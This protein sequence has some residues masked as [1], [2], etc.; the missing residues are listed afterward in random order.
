MP[1]Y[2]DIYVISNSRESGNIER[3]LNRFLPEREES[4]DEYEFPQYSDHPEN[5]YQTA[6]ELLERCYSETGIEYVL[7][8]R[9]VGARKPEHAMVFFLKDDNLVYGLSTD[10][11]YPE[12]ATELLKEMKSFLNSNL[13]YIGYEAS[14]DVANLEEFKRQINAH[15][16]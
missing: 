14:P 13:G 3:F 6:N 7:Y 15:K 4:A 11:A 9:A 1:S 2:S 12:Y 10:D 16:P 5:V 8:W